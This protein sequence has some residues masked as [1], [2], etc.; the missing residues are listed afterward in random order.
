VLL[1]TLVVVEHVYNCASL[2]VEFERLMQEAFRVDRTY[3]HRFSDVWLWME[4]PDRGNE[5]DTGIDLVAKNADGGYTLELPDPDKKGRERIGRALKW[6]EHAD[7]VR[8]ERRQ[9]RESEVI[10]REDSGRGADYTPPGRTYLEIRAANRASPE[11][12]YHRYLTPPAEFWLK[13]TIVELDATAIA[14][15]LILLSEHNFRGR[16]SLTAA[17]E[18]PQW[19]SVSQW[20]RRFHLSKE[21]RYR[22]FDK[23]A[24]A[25]IVEKSPYPVDPRNVGADPR[26]VRKRYALV[27]YKL[28]GREIRYLGHPAAQ[29]VGSI[30]WHHAL[31]RLPQP[32][33]ARC[34]RSVGSRGI[35][36]CQGSR[37]PMT[38]RTHEDA[39]SKNE[40]RA[41]APTRVRG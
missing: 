41:L 28:D 36:D 22:G 15:L 12:K 37:R 9:G 16:G 5:P 24:E 26:R 35:T 13:R 31:Q 17:S 21:T 10:L 30:G 39:M 11:L 14:A 18:D 34:P 38:A 32:G 8:R 7:L 40:R 20:E 1:A 2:R 29:R 33:G 3:R 4:W 27:D 23:L 25:R 6:L 19:W